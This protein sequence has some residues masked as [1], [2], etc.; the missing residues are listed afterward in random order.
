MQT[1]YFSP[2][3]NNK[4]NGPKTQNPSGGISRLLAAAVINKGFR[5]LLL[6]HP[7]EA[8][9]QGYCGEEFALDH[10]EKKLVLSLQAKDLSELA[11]QITT[12]QEDKSPH[13]IRYWIPVNQPAIV[14]DAE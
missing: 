1:R 3:S 8:L 2:A 12:Y 7:A 13:G 6:T 5:D 10:N 4:Q 14:L 9:A 11:R